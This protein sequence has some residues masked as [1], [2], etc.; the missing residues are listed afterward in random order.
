MH[1]CINEKSKRELFGNNIGGKIMVAKYE[2]TTNCPILSRCNSTFDY[3]FH[4]FFSRRFYPVCFSQR[5]E[6][7]DS[8]EI[9]VYRLIQKL[10]KNR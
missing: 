1:V 3:S 7:L 8:T 5:E 2:I 10:R 4:F 6:G 9:N